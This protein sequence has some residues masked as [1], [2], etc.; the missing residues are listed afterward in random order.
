MGSLQIIL[1]TANDERKAAMMRQF[2]EL[3]IGFFCKIHVLEATTPET[4]NGYIPCDEND[5]YK[6]RTLCCA[7]S[8]IR[9]II[10]AAQD[11]STDFSIIMEDDAALDTTNFIAGVTEIVEN[12]DIL[13]PADS[14]MVSIGW[15]SYTKYKDFASLQSRSKFKFNPNTKLLEWFAYGTQAY[16]IKK[17]SA[18]D[19][20][21]LLDHSTFAALHKSVLESNSQHI[22]KNDPILACDKWLNRLLVQSL[23]APL[24]VIEQNQVKSTIEVGSTYHDD[25]WKTHFEG[26]EL[27]MKRYWSYH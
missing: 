13:I 8:H 19:F 18:K 4:A 20:A 11:S 2:T 6:I 3:N 5:L 22:P 10:H 27:E 24:L 25:L 12:W 26:H 15:I 1:I 7:K 16:I 17:T 23:I 14:H 21:P 9:A